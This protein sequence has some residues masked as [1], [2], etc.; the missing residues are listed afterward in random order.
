MKKIA[1]IFLVTYFSFLS[2][3]KTINEGILIE[4]SFTPALTYGPYG[5][6]FDEY[7]FKIR[8]KES[9]KTQ[10]IHVSKQIYDHYDIGDMFPTME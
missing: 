7:M 9:H 5:P 8:I 4:K 10:K 3:E 2:C 6:P 1:F